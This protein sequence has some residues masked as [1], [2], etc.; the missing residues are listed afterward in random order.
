MDSE[1]KTYDEKGFESKDPSAKAREV[2]WNRFAVLIC[3]ADLSRRIDHARYK[4]ILLIPGILE[5]ISA[6]MLIYTILVEFIH[7]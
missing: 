2:N 4:A 1:I 3:A 5:A 7:V 6:G